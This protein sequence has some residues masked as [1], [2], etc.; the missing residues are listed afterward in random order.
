MLNCQFG[1]NTI[2][3]GQ[4]GAIAS[5]GLGTLQVGE[6]ELGNLQAQVL[7]KDVQG[8]KSTVDSNLCEIEVRGV[9]VVARNPTAVARGADGLLIEVHPQP[10]RALTDGQQSLTIAQFQDLM[11]ELRSIAEAVGRSL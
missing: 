11:T 8:T 4:G 6:C 5:T 2:S 3:V 1:N 9:V 10:E 7:A